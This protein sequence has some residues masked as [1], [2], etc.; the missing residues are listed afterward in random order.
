MYGKGRIEILVDKSLRELN[1]DCSCLSTGSH[2]KVFVRCL[3]CGEEFKREFRN[4]HQSHAC[5]THIIREDGTKLKW[6]NSCCSFLA[7]EAF[8]INNIRYDNLSS[9][10]KACQCRSHSRKKMHERQKKKRTTPNGWIKWAVTRKKSECKRKGLEFNIDAQYMIDQYEKQNN[11]CFY[12]KTPLKFGVDDLRSAT[13]E[14]INSSLG[15]TRGNV[16]LSCKAMN[17]AK[18]SSTESD[19]L[20][21][22]LELLNSLSSYVRLET[23]IINADGMLPF[24]K[25]TSDAG[26]DLYSSED[27]VIPPRTIKSI[28]TGIIIS[29]PEGTYFTIEGRSS[30]FEAGVT[31]YRGIIDA[32]YQGHLFIML[33]NNSDIPYEIKKHDR[34]AQLVL[35]PIIHADF[36]LV[37]EFAPIQDGRVDDGWGSSGK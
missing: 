3:R 4:L 31:P 2:Q 6:C 11:T 32:T 9:L 8:T 13:L 20:R 18:N 10:C 23:K 19:F 7:Y 29:P 37:N 5:P 34:I 36:V 22:L 1:V 12:A 33:M 26:Y 24:R 14:R 28:G 17:W 15:Y 16:V 21:F 35:H 30:V 25:R 27:A